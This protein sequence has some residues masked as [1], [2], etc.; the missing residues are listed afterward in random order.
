MSR[1]RLNQ[2][3][4]TKG[5][6]TWVDGIQADVSGLIHGG[7]FGYAKDWSGWLNN[8]SYTSRPLISFLLQA[9]IGFKLLPGAEVY[10]ATL[11]SLIENIRH[12]ITGLNQTEEVDV[13]SNQSWGGSGQ[14]YQV[15]T[16]VKENQSNVTFTYWERMG[17]SIYRFHAFWVRMLMM[18]KETKYAGISTVAGTE[19]YDALPD[20]YSMSVL[21]IEPDP[22]HR[23]VVQAWLGINMWPQTTGENEA[24]FDKDDPS[25][26]RAVQI[27]YSGIYMY[28]TGVDYFAQRFLNNIKLIGANVYHQAVPSNLGQIDALVANAATGYN[29]SV[30][31]VSR[32][33]LR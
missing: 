29:Q 5:Q 19:A 21:F 28:S 26:T 18:D 31:N 6:G 16:N 22:T 17:L 14:K 4:Q 25:T 33:Q 11:R 3:H 2:V 15:F 1:T 12:Q 32:T 8:H 23:K 30:T 10:I 13:D 7:N 24:K 27:R 9:P 20:M